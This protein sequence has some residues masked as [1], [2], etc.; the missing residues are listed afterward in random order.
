[1]RS[2]NGRHHRAVSLV[3]LLASTAVMAVLITGMGSAMFIASRAVP[4][5][6]S[7]FALTRAGEDTLH[8]LAGDLLYATSVSA[9]TETAITFTVADRGHGSAG[10]E[11]VGYAWSGTPGDPLTRQYNTGAVTAIAED[12][13]AFQ[14]TYHVDSAALGPPPTVETAESALSSRLAAVT[15]GDFTV[16][17]QNWIGQYFT[18]QLPAEAIA[19][20]VTRVKFVAR[21]SGLALGVTAVQLRPATAQHE[22]LPEVLEEVLMLETSLSST[23]RW[24]EFSFGT[25]SGL[26]PTE[27]LC[28][29]LARQV[30]DLQLADIQFNDAAGSGRLTTTDAGAFWT[31]D[32]AQSMLYAVYGTATIPDPNPPP[33]EQPLRSVTARIQLG[34][35]VSTQVQTEIQLH[36]APDISGL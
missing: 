34:A 29:V 5:G 13:R 3:E 35:D 21:S 1:M 25:V 36:N 32:A 2:H 15:L 8:Q 33:A 9:K 14:L 17:D 20:K 24:Q 26:S 27:G 6:S 10:P 18:P 30:N 28:L 11:S 4:D 7:P 12:V 23:Y 19:W 16:T 31:N 22:P